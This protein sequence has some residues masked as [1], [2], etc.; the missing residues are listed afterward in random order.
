[1]GRVTGE[2]GSGIIKK[3]I[4]EE[5]M[6]V[7]TLT[8]VKDFLPSPS[9]IAVTGKVIKVTNS[10]SKYSVDFFKQQDS[11]YHTKYQRMI[12]VL[13]DKYATQYSH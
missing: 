8:R 13:L 12:R 4:R 11:Q 10:L 2:K 6:P 5:N 9:Q 3:K 1:L 7:G